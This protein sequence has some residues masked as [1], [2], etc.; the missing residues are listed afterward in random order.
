MAPAIIGNL[1][2]TEAPVSDEDFAK[3]VQSSEVPKTTKA[4]QMRKL[5]NGWVLGGFKETDL[6]AMKLFKSASK[7]SWNA[8]GLTFAEEDK[9]RDAE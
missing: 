3:L 8:L 4:E 6:N 2:Q 9:I 1:T 5:Y 7:K